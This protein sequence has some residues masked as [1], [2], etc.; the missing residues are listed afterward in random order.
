MRWWLGLGV[1]W[2]L[3]TAWSAPEQ[4]GWTVAAHLDGRGGLGRAAAKYEADLASVRGELTGLAIQRIS[5]VS[6]DGHG[7]VRRWRVGRDGSRQ[8]VAAMPHL[9]AGASSDKI[10]RTF[11]AWAHPTNDRRQLVV[12]AMGHGGGLI[13]ETEPSG[14]LSFGGLRAALAA[15][16]ADAT[17]VGLVGLDTC[18]G[19]TL[20]VAYELRHEA[21]ALTA[22]PGVIYS[23]GLDWATALRS[24]AKWADDPQRLAKA[25]VG[26]GMPAAAGRPGMLTGLDLTQARATS[27]ALGRLGQVLRA[28]LRRHARVI[29]LVRSRTASWGSNQELCDLGQLAQGLA[30]NAETDELRT[31][32]EDLRVAVAGMTLAHWTNAPA[33]GMRPGSG[34]GLYFPASLET[35]PEGYETA[36]QL[37]RD[38][39]WAEFLAA[40]WQQL[41]Q[42]FD[43]TGGELQTGDGGGRTRE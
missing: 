3:G 40:Y 38:S 34:L 14:S 1:V 2:G 29:A 36:W 21:L 35:L 6:D 27:E 37:G 28:D 17:P 30:E 11:M 24:S 12:L 31:A 15:D 22:A 7:V 10:L 25:V 43:P 13:G 9:P 42:L 8:R 32:A 5:T 26:Q 18:Y 16:R 41:R 33:E 19:A 23:P 39:G 4:T 20:E